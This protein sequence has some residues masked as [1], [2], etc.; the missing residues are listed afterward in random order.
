[1]QKRHVLAVTAATLALPLLAACG[2]VDTGS[3]SGT[4]TTTT[5]SSSADTGS[6]SSASSS[7]SSGSTSTGTSQSDTGSTIDPATQQQLVALVQ[8]AY[9]EAQLGLHRGHQPIQD[10]L[11][12]VLGISHDELHVRMEQQGQNLAAVAEDLG[13]DPQT[14]IDA[15][16]A[17]WSTSVQDALDSGAIDEQ[18]AAAYTAALEEAFTYRVTW[19]GSAA[20][21]TFT[22]V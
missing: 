5:S 17:S 7:A 14:L 16:V 18:Q 2:T 6:S 21:P 15:L 13:I 9:G 19:D 8:E 4:S 10:V 11:T 1:M 12:E 22:G 20:T 3:T